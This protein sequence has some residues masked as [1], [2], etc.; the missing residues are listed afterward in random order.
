MDYFELLHI[1][2]ELIWFL[3]PLW[4]QNIT[5]TLSN[6]RVFTFYKSMMDCPNW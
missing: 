3:A 5:W 2:Y 6:L 1:V 4:E